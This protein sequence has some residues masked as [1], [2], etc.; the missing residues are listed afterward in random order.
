V[1]AP[2]DPSGNRMAANSFAWNRAGWRAVEMAAVEGWCRPMAD[3]IA[4][5]C[6][7]ESEQAEHPGHYQGKPTTGAEKRG[8]RAG[9]EG[10]ASKTLHQGRYR[11]TV[12]TTTVPAMADNA[13]HNRLIGNLHIAE[14][15]E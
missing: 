12:I 3:K 4:D 14:G 2:F 11:A 8:Y 10:E 1:S 7:E 9:T 5:R 6:N 13:R 15:G